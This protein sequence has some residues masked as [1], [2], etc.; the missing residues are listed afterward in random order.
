MD[1]IDAAFKGNLAGVQAAIRAGQDVNKTNGVTNTLAHKSVG[2]TRV[3]TLRRL[4]L[5][6]GRTAAIYAACNG[7][8]DC[9]T[10]L[11]GAGADL[12]LKDKVRHAVPPQSLSFAL[13][14]RFSNFTARCFACVEGQR[15]AY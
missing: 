7:H 8:S 6:Y 4:L 12:R 3:A 15:N 14:M 10:A 1:I 5:Q 13:G 2:I 11:I 9:L